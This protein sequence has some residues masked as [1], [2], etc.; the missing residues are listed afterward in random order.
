MTLTLTCNLS[1]CLPLSHT[2][3]IKI[4][5]RSSAN[6]EKSLFAKGSKYFQKYLLIFL[7]LKLV[8]FFL[9]F[10][11]PDSPLPA[12]SSF[13]SESTI[14]PPWQDKLNNHVYLACKNESMHG[15]LLI[16]P[17]LNRNSVLTNESDFSLQRDLPQEAVRVS[18]VKLVLVKMLAMAWKVVTLNWGEAN[19]KYVL[20]MERLV[21]QFHVVE[22][23]VH[24]SM[25]VMIF[26]VIF[27]L[28]RFLLKKRWFAILMIRRGYILR[29]AGLAEWRVFSDRFNR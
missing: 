23:V 22:W 19:G 18:L 8:Y 14:Q 2:L 17:F 25:I 4:N 7:A 27:F 24:Y 21:L 1:L 15:E 20:A 13:Y 6:I 26:A 28:R 29:L 5:F 11:S 9:L 12:I 16:S 3:F 10:Q